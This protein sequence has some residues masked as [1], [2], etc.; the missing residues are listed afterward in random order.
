[1]RSPW[2][3]EPGGD[4]ANGAVAGVLESQYFNVGDG[5]YYTDKVEVRLIYDWV[6]IPGTGP[7]LG[8][9]G[10]PVSGSWTVMEGKTKTWVFGLSVAVSGPR[11]S[12][13]TGNIGYQS[14]TTTTI[15]E[16][17]TVPPL[18]GEPGVEYKAVALQQ[19]IRQYFVHV[20]P[21]PPG[22]QYADYYGEEMFLGTGV[23]IYKRNA[24]GSS[25]G[26]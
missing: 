17:I 15:G 14:A 22:K 11:E 19:R 1:M 23:R 9:A 4:P 25:N 13:I 8:N 3:S 6:V 16:T 7:K 5:K 21:P 2:Y 10:Q 12:K 18:P 20:N 26:E 24:S